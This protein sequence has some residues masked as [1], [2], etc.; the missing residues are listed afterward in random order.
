MFET[1]PLEY[2]ALNHMI[3][4]SGKSY[5]EV[6]EFLYPHRKPSSAYVRLKACLNP[7]KADF[8]KFG[9]IIAAMKFCNRYDPLYYACDETDH[10]RP[11]TV[12]KEEKQ[13]VL[14][15]EFKRGIE[16]LEM[17]KS[18]LERVSNG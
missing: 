9:Q 16:R 8:L 3:K 10:D 6:A 18:E 14:T 4:H 13:A 12:V 15:E 11:K 2:E 17:L 1:N 5:R 7:D